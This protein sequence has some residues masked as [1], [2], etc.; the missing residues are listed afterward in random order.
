MLSDSS[1]MCVVY[2]YIQVHSTIIWDKMAKHVA[3]LCYYLRMSLLT[4]IVQVLTSGQQVLVCAA[5]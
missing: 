1:Y 2:D 5:V 3:D 4:C